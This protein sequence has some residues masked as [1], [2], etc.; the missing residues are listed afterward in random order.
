MTGGASVS[1]DFIKKADNYKDPSHNLITA[2]KTLQKQI[3]DKQVADLKAQQE[4]LE[5]AQQ[6]QAAQEAA[7]AAATAPAPPPA[8]VAP[9]IVHNDNFY[10]DY[11][12]SHE[13]GNSLT[14]VNS[15][16]CVGLGQSCGGGLES[17]CP[18]W[19][20]DYTCQLNYFSNYATSRYGSW[21]ASY[22]FW[23][24]NRWW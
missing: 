1:G 24:N 18:N 14:S 9:V 21:E 8:P 5:Q 3:D 2:I 17:T 19:S 20:T 22:Q 12:F 10:I 7:Q 11:I 4:A 16:G 23:L 13:S 15:V 6:A